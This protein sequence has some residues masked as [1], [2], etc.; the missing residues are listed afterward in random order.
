VDR[1]SR[2]RVDNWGSYAREREEIANLIDALG[3]TGR[4][5]MLSGDAH[6]VAID[7]GTHSNYATG[8]GRGQ[9]WLRRDARGSLD[10]RTSGKGGPYSHGVS[11]QR[12]QFGLVEVTDDG[13]QL[14][15]ELSGRD[16][17]GARIPG[18][19]LALACA[20]S[21]CDITPSAK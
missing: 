20:D 17:A 9:A 5:L 10:R 13:Q 2:F 1:R 6:M 14:S 15:V 3:L 4:L 8:T 18:M 11:K 21:A 7:D 19:R 16:R 12:G